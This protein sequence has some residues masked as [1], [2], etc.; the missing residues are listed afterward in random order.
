MI[1]RRAVLLSLVGLLLGLPVWATDNTPPEGFVPLFNG[2][3]LPGWKVP[4]GD[5]GHWKVVDGVIDYDAES[6]APGDKIALDRARV[7]ATSSCTWT[8]GSRRRPFVNKNVPYI[9]P[10]GTHARDIHGKELRLALPDA[11]SGVFLRGDRQFQ[12]NIWCWPIGSGEMYGIRTDPKTPPELRA[13]V[14]PR[15]QADRPVGEWNHFEITVQGKTVKVVLNGKTVIPGPPSHDL[16][17]RGRLALQHHGG[18]NKQGVWSGPPSLVQFKN[19]YHQGAARPRRPPRPG[20]VRALLITGGHDHEAAFYS[21]F[22]GYK[23]LD[24]LPV[25]S[26]DTAFQS[27]LRG[28]YDVLIMYDFSRDLDETGRKNL[29]DFV[30]AAGVVVL[31]HALLNYQNW[32]WW[33]EEVVGGSYRLRGGRQS[34]VQLKDDQQIF[35][36]RERTTRSQ[37]DRAFPGA[38]RN[39]Q[40]HVDFS[41]GPAAADHRQ[42]HQRRHSPGSARARHRGWSPS[43]W[44][45]GPPRSQSV[46]PDAGAQRHPLGGRKAQM[47]VTSAAGS[48]L[49]APQARNCDE[50]RTLQHH[51]PGPL[52][53]RRGSAASGDDRAGPSSTATTGSRSTASGR[54]ATRSTG[55]RPLPRAAVHRRRRRDRDLTPSPPTTTSATPCPRS[56]RPRS[57]L[58]AT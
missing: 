3:D 5:N 47:T 48:V 26:S 11:D 14:T 6:E 24:R 46:V 50:T 28:K 7:S 37:R 36:A 16:P 21:L 39:L 54:T 25:S 35:V 55:R 40:K 45:T 56:A 41:P 43:S 15:T 19:V 33:Y 51:L 18:K 22:D 31:H 17:D 13:A 52:V 32:A 9:L 30:E 49:R 42:P 4:D 2:K 44:G 27:D 57:A 29:R 58:S 38:G 8:G 10:D 1:T 53:S 20:T 23:D 12:V 34:L